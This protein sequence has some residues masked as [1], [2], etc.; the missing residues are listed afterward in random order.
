MTYL[1]IIP[2]DPAL[3]QFIGS[4][5]NVVGG[6][7]FGM[8]KTSAMFSQLVNMMANQ[9]RHSLGPLGKTVK[10]VKR[11]PFSY[12][13]YSDEKKVSWIENGLPEF[14]M[15]QTHP[16]G[17][18]SRVVKPRRR[19]N[20]ILTKWKAKR[21]DGTIYTVRAGDKYNIV[22][23]RHGT[24]KGTRFT[25]GR[26]NISELRMNQL[27]MLMNKVNS[28]QFSRSRVTT[29]TSDSTYKTPNALGKMIERAQYK[30]GDRLELP[31]I[32][33]NQD[34]QGVVAMSTGGST[35]FMSFRVVS[36]NSPDGSWIHKAVPGKHT[37]QRIAAATIPTMSK[38]L[39]ATMKE[40]L[41]L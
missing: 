15:K 35:Q 10:V 18:K 36:Q 12:E 40:D 41:G 31:D 21:K 24:M 28:K 14:D 26:E 33:E 25:G 27:H 4:I 29:S 11:G 30:W 17:P 1:S 2:D 5:N 7:A 13:I 16:N 32:P 8:K 37:P 19:G 38:I 6:T 9:W 20:K 3:A 22:P 23:F 34:I 39:Q